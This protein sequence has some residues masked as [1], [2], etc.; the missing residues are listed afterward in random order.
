MAT[1]NALILSASIAPATRRM[2]GH[3][4]RHEQAA[5][6]HRPEDLLHDLA[7]G[8]VARPAEQVLGAG[9]GRVG[10]DADRHLGEVVDRER[11]EPGVA[12]AGDRHDA[13]ATSGRGRRGC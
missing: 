4:H 12:L 1:G 6:A 11:L 2:S 10:E 5:R 8:P 13:R 9:G 3:R 7:V